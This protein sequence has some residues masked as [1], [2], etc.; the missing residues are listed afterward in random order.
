MKIWAV[1]GALMSVLA[2]A[3]SEPRAENE[4]PEPG[5]R[6][7]GRVGHS[8][9]GASFYVWDEDRREA[10]GW[11]LELAEAWARA[12]TAAQPGERDE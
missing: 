5:E 12:I 1:I 8:I 2:A 10:E 4:R 6:G 3:P 7:S 9:V 11:A